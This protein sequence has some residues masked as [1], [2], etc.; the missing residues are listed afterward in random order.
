MRFALRLILPRIVLAA[1]TL[2]AISVIIFTLVELLPGDAA[3]RV[4][5]RNAT[6][7]NVEVWRK[8][9]NLDRPPVTRYL[10]WARDFV[11][12]DWGVSL[13][14]AQVASAGN[15]GG[16]TMRPVADLVLPRLKNTLILT[17]YVMA[18]SIPASLFLGIVTAVF[19]E[20]RFATWLSGLV[21]FG[22]SMPDYVIGVLMLL[23]FTVSLGWFPALA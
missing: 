6:A 21:L 10:L 22:V 11:R 3:T 16:K 14:S 2:A 15:P 19:R 12:G 20:R 1:L 18:I 23:V 13:V 17:L 5:G 7:E 9:F 4:L 8:R